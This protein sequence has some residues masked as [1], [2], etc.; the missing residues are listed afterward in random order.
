MP[1]RRVLFVCLGNACR[2]QMAEGFAR[3]YGKDVMTPESAGL[4][5]A[6]AVPIETT[7]TMAEK[8]IDISAQFPKPVSMFPQGHFDR[9]VNMS[10][11]PMPSFPMATE[12]KVRDP[13]GGTPYGNPVLHLGD[14]IVRMWRNWQT[15]WVQVSVLAREWRFKSS[16]PHQL[17][18]ILSLW[19]RCMVLHQPNIAAH[20][21][22]SASGE[23]ENIGGWC[24]G[25]S[26]NPSL[27]SSDFLNSP[28]PGP[29][30]T[31]AR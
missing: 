21:C 16:H 29:G 7:Q 18:L 11:Y 13:I 31:S 1:H 8:N 9:V 5:P 19:G 23:S 30:S 20:S 28:L 4:A 25:M 6:M 26:L 3:A 10:G 2:S 17:F 15:R 12:W 14:R 22:F 27:N 24:D